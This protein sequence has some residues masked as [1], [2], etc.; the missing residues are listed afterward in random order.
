[1]ADAHHTQVISTAVLLS[2][3]QFELLLFS[4]NRD[5]KEANSNAQRER[6]RSIGC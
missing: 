1:M 4:S 6:R 5:A 2:R 3:W